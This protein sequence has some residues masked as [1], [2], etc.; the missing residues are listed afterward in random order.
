MLKGLKDPTNIYDYV[1]ALASCVF[2]QNVE[3]PALSIITPI[4]MRGLNDKKTATKRL[5]CIIIDNMCKLIEHPKEI[6][7]FYSNLKTK[8][9]FCTETISDPEARKISDRALNTLKSCC[10]VDEN[11]NF[12]KKHQDFFDL[13]DENIK[14]ALPINLEYLSILI[15]NMC[16]SHFL[17]EKEWNNV[18]QKYVSLNNEENDII[19]LRSFQLFAF[20]L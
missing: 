2:V 11:T 9:E 16:N 4:L 7:P 17:D 19:F 8:L 6:L 15:T 13:L 5:S 18:F 20:F 1:E 12:Y 10:S 14:Y 3:A